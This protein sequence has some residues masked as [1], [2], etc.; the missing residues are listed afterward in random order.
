MLYNIG[1]PE[2]NVMVRA[3]C[4]S[5][6]LHPCPP[7]SDMTLIYQVVYSY[8]HCHWGY[9]DYEQH[10][11]WPGFVLFAISLEFWFLCHIYMYI[12]RPQNLIFDLFSLVQS[13]VL[14]SLKTLSNF[15]WL[16]HFVRSD[17]N[18]VLCNILAV[19]RPRMA[20]L[21]TVFIVY[22]NV[23]N[24]SKFVNIYSITASSINE[25]PHKITINNGY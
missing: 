14:Y 15:T 1:T 17:G 8:C 25:G 21:W 22:L 6:C 10:R 24:V 4:S 2:R 20:P 18:S 13:V 12:H 11:F 7:L 19:G 23:L 9:H 16:Q 5:V 3:V